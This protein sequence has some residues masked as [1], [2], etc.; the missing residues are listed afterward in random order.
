M[1]K[2]WGY[3]RATGRG[4]PNWLQ[5]PQ[6]APKYSVASPSVTRVKGKGKTVLVFQGLLVVM[7]WS[8]I[9]EAH[10]ASNSELPIMS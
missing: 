6:L 4:A 7:C 5:K 8:K 3:I 2:G 1:P 9:Y 10:I